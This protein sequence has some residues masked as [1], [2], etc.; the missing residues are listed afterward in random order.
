MTTITVQVPTALLVEAERA[1][2]ANTDANVE[3]KKLMSNG[4]PARIA[5]QMRTFAE[6]NRRL[7]RAYDALAAAVANTPFDQ[8]CQVAAGGMENQA[9]ILDQ[10]VARIEGRQA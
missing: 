4:A 7:A 3:L 8:P 1:M 5:M 2:Q 10:Q 6:A 9:Q